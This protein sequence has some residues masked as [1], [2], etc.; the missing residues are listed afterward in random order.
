[1][2]TKRRITLHSRYQERAYG[3]EKEVPWLNVSGLWLEKLGFKAGD[4]VEITM[5]EKLLIIQPIEQVA[6]DQE[7]YKARFEEVERALKK[8]L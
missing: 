3:A 5:R 7:D 2:S 8:L 4:K 1:M 6:E